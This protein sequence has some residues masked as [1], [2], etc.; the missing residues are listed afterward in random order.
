ML[1]TNQA[2]SAT[3]I[4]SGE[5]DPGKVAETRLHH[6]VMQSFW[7]GH[8]DRC[9][10]YSQKYPTSEIGHLRTIMVMFYAALSTFHGK[11]GY[12]KSK[13]M[14]ASAKNGRFFML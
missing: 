11:A 8:Y 12:K 13:K 10:F 6:L 14:I 9:L 7:S 2:S 4:A 5:D 3:L 1:L